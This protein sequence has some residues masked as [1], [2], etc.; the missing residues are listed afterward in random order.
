MKVSRSV[1]FLLVAGMTILTLFL[2]VVASL[3]FELSEKETTL[4]NPVLA[5]AP[6]VAPTKRVITPE[7]EARIR[8]SV[9]EQKASF[10]EAPLKPA[11]EVMPMLVRSAGLFLRYTDE[12]RHGFDRAEVAL[13]TIKKI[14]GYEQWFRER[15]KTLFPPGSVEE[16]TRYGRRKLVASPHPNSADANMELCAIN[17]VLEMLSTDE[18]IRVSADYL[19]D[20]RLIYPPG[21]DYGSY[22]LA[23]ESIQVLK[24]ISRDRKLV[25]VPTSYDPAD[26][27]KWWLRVKANYGA[28]AQ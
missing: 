24:I 4:S 19:W 26:W 10:L 14:P 15:L 17:R 6:V 21:D 8:T 2:A 28:P 25:G 13:A 16:N 7:E 23:E 1:C 22:T 20:D 18:A 9:A 11:A 27:Q 5:I 3:Q 12:L